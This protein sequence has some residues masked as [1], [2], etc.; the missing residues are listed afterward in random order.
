MLLVVVASAIAVSTSHS[1]VLSHQLQTLNAL[2]A[3]CDDELMRHLEAGSVA[4]AIQSIRLSHEVDRKTPLAIDET[5]NPADQSFLLIVR[6]RRI[7]TAR[8]ANTVGV[9]SSNEYRGIH[10]YS[11]I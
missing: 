4:F 3:L 1:E 11:S 5:G 2:R 7:V 8:L 10:G 9:R 6:I